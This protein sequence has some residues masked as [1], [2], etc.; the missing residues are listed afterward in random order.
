MES[1]P[2][3]DTCTWPAVR[4]TTGVPPSAGGNCA[5]ACPC[6]TCCRCL[7]SSWLAGGEGIVVEKGMRRDDAYSAHA[8]ALV[9]LNLHPAIAFADLGPVFGRAR[10][11]QLDHARK[12][13]PDIPLRARN[14]AGVEDAHAELR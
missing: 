12:T 2:S 9:L 14:A 13:C 1:N 8:A 3:P 5:M 10:L 11:E 4:A 6:R 7:T